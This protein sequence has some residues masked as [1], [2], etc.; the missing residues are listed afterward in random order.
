[1]EGSPWGGR[2]R[3][4]HFKLGVLLCTAFYITASHHLLQTSLVP[5]KKNLSVCACPNPSLD[6][7]N[8]QERRKADFLVSSHR[9]SSGC[10]H[11]TLFA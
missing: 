9:H 1:M 3:C 7:R 6:D 4:W 8:L 5:L 11:P 2:Q 10:L